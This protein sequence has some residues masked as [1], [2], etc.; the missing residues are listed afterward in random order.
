MSKKYPTSVKALLLNYGWSL[1]WVLIPIVFA[2]LRIFPEVTITDGLLSVLFGGI[3]LLAKY[4]HVKIK[5]LGIWFDLK[6]ELIW[7]AI[8]SVVSFIAIISDLIPFLA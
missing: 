6:G 8:I 3:G 5:P 4:I 7:Y 2:S 1:L